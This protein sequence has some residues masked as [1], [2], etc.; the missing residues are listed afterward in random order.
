ML[1]KRARWP[2]LATALVAL[3]LG[4]GGSANGSL[5]QPDVVTETPASYTPHLAASSAV[6]H[7]V[8]LTIDKWR[9]KMFVGGN[10]EVVANAEQTAFY[11]R[12]NIM[13]F[14]PTT[15]VIADG[16]TPEIDGKVFAIRGVGNSVF[17]GGDFNTV[18]GV[19]RPALVKLNASTGAIDPTFDSSQTI[20]DGRV[21][22]IRLV[23]GRLLVGG[24]FPDRL[25]A[26]DPATGAD[27]NYINVPITG[28]LRLSTNRT[29]VHKFAVNPQGTRLV[30]VGNFT[31]VDGQNRQRAFMLALGSAGA[32]L[33][34]WYYQ[35]LNR[36]CS[37]DGPSLQAYLEDVDFS[38][39]G[40]YFVFVSTGFVP[41]TELEI[42][43]A[44][45]DAAARF[46][47][48]NPAPSSPTWINYTGGDTLHSVA[49]TGAAV[50]VQGHSRWLDNPY[51]QNA[52]GPGAVSRPGIGAI[53][54][55]TGKALEWNPIKPAAQGGHDFLVTQA[56]L[57][58]VSDSLRFNGQYHRGIAFAP[59]P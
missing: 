10:F 33:R 55:L 50:Y 38:P 15:G 23:N 59:L 19:A 30:A 27:T 1:R 39:D 41:S 40:S 46:E 58:V 45:C 24:T 34:A 52:A 20:P 49:V 18:N 36:K 7:P 26:L 31:T 53:D 56:G 14:D 11:P 44:L 2:L 9:G 35:P 42:G 25:L 57:W 5:A 3:V 12:G 6:P 21:S 17:V 48:N 37:A 28:Q 4:L 16:F 32:S 47:T 8:A 29:E 22:E 13:A 54:P 43:T 51:G